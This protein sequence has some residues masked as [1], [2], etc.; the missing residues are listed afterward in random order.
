MFVGIVVVSL[1]SLT[2]ATLAEAVDSSMMTPIPPQ[3]P[4][5]PAVITPSI[6]VNAISEGREHDR[7][8][9]HA[10]AFA[11]FSLILLSTI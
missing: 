10:C 7:A 3:A 11:C 9:G 5:A 6:V 4:P 8:L 2:L 1:R